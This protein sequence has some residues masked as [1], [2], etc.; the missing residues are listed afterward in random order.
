VKSL[1]RRNVALMVGIVLAGQLLAG[2]LVMALVV[3]PQVQR[4]ANVT[5]DMISGLSEAMELMPEPRRNAMIARIE[6]GGQLLI[7]KGATPPSLG[8]DRPRRPN[9]IERQ[10]VT[11]LSARLARNRELAWRTASDA[12]LWFRLRLGGEEYWVS[13][14]PPE[15]RGALTSFVLSFGAAFIVAAVFGLLLQRR[16]DA[17]LRR[18]AGAVDAWEPGRPS[19]PLDTS[20]PQEIAAVAGAFNRLTERL[21]R[22]EAERSLMLGGVS[23]DLRTPLTR[24]RLCLDMMHGEDEDLQ[25]TAERQ[26]D[27]I[28][29]MLEQFLDFARGF[30]DEAAERVNVKALLE[31]IANDADPSGAIGLEVD[32]A[33]A[34]ALRRNAVARAVGNLVGNALRHGATP[35]TISA[36]LDRTMLEIVVSDAGEGFAPDRAGELLQPFAR[37][38]SARSGD[39]AGLGLAIA[40]RVAAAHGGSL[41]FVRNDGA[42]RAVMLLAPRAC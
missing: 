7:R 10:F 22:N 32:P 34:F 17:P 11:A 29:A 18:L 12:R 36:S 23:H 30:E 24:L 1:L 37:G 21:S 42:F 8:Q 28:E 33:L 5:A 3:R 25:R 41:R 2:L 39:G 15:S 27:R 9:F 40:A 16:L 13:V 19:A 35:V 26:V 31:S 14:T 6:Q 20:G 4:V 38:N